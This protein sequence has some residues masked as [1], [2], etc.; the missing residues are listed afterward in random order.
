MQQEIAIE[1]PAPGAPRIFRAQML[2]A[3]TVDALDAFFNRIHAHAVACGGEMVMLID[4]RA[5]NPR[6][7]TSLHRRRAVAYLKGLTEVFG[8]R[9]GGQIIVFQNPMQRGILTAITWLFSPPWPL[10][11]VGDLETAEATAQELAQRRAAMEVA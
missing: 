7:I 8:D 1:A 2:Q 10:K 11:I 4:G 5:V 9:F 3:P 6:A